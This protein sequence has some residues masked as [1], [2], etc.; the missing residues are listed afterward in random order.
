MKGSCKHGSNTLTL[1]IPQCSQTIRLHAVD[2]KKVLSALWTLCHFIAIKWCWPTTADDRWKTGEH[3]GI[4]N[5]TCPTILLRNDSC[6]LQDHTNSPMRNWNRG[7]TKSLANNSP[8]ARYILLTVH[9][10]SLQPCA[11]THRTDPNNMHLLVLK[12][13]S[14]TI[15]PLWCPPRTRWSYW[16]HSLSRP[17][18]EGTWCRA[19]IDNNGRAWSRKRF[20][21]LALQSPSSETSYLSDAHYICYHLEPLHPKESPRR[22]DGGMLI[23]ETLKND[24]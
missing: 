20:H 16:S 22:V 2:N 6:R 18:L 7:G 10:D 14:T 24:K 15:P 9:M 12:G 23:G 13:C 19:A 8:A 4:T 5:H 3:A 1:E 11:K 17:M 21:Y